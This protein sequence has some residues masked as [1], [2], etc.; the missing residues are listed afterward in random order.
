MNFIFTI[1]CFDYIIH[2]A[3]IA[4]LFRILFIADYTSFQLTSSGAMHV[5]AGKSHRTITT[6]W[7][8][9]CISFSL[10]D[11]TC[12]IHAILSGYSVCRSVK[13]HI[14]ITGYV[15]FSTA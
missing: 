6:S 8:F 12:T 2:E 3:V 11:N 15:L 13:L 5:L 7:W 4:T 9:I 1:S 14:N 10:A